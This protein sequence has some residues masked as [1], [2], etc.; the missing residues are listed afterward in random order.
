M[1]KNFILVIVIL[2]SFISCSG[3]KTIS[4]GLNRNLYSKEFLIKINGIKNIYSR[5]NSNLALERLSKIDI[6]TIKPIE[7]SLRRNLIGVILFSQGEFEKAI[8]NFNLAVD[9]S[10]VDPSLGA[11]IYLNLASSYYKLGFNE[12]SLAAIKD[13]NFE[14]LNS[15]DAKKH[16]LLSFKLNVNFENDFE[17]VK[18]LV[19]YLLD[20][21]KIDE[22]REE[23]Y[24]ESLTNYYFKLSD[25]AQYKI[26]QFYNEK[27]SLVV[28]YLGY[29][30]SEKIY[31]KGNKSKAKEL[32]GWVGESYENNSELT[33][34]IERFNN[35][36]ENISKLNQYSVGL[37]LPLTGSKKR[38][39]KRAFYGIDF[40]LKMASKENKKLQLFVKDSKG[41]GVVGAMEVEKLIEKNNVSV[42]IGGLFSSEAKKEYLIAKKHGVFFI[43]LSPI[44]LPKEEKGHLL[45][46]IP[47]SVESQVEQIF[48]DEML[49]KFGNRAAII[50]PRT[51]RGNTYL[52]EFWRKASSKGVKVIGAFG[53]DKNKTDYR[54]P[55]SN[56][57]GLKFKR[58][59]KEEYELLQEI[60]SL[61]KKG[62]IRRIQTLK[63]QVDFDW[64]FIPAFPREALLL[65]P[66]FSYFDAYG[67]NVI[68]GPSWRSKLLA[69]ERIKSTKV[70][71]VGDD[72]ESVNE[73][74]I[75]RFQETYN[76]GPK[77]IELRSIDAF[78][79]AKFLVDQ[80]EFASREE[81][82]FHIRKQ[83]LIQGLTGSWSLKDGIWIKKMAS[84]GIFSGKFQKILQ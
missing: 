15:N 46:E 61:E 3:I 32:L 1:I 59:R 79:I 57:L 44:Y 51:E 8:Y 24:F 82:D 45:L 78:S 84:L 33:V 36:L 49:A 43:S 74:I 64:V 71:F 18:S 5:G 4:G 7:N 12:K 63:P 73:E 10:R 40:S 54:G 35:R 65:I 34:L 42:I 80:E 62:M 31:Y 60:H 55:V 17:T 50:Y 14:N 9:G 28:G 11:Q 26:L 76:S 27:D 66:S 29:L 72:I 21:K 39:G 38:F 48:S 47:G 77:I 58:E 67:L 22:L 6:A 70:H 68:G 83:E 13:S 52:D 30:L 53:F 69:K 81:F 16:H 25:S 2:V 37:V 75:N 23:H 20:R 41:S 56:L 19:M